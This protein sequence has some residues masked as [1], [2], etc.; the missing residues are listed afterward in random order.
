MDGP[1]WFFI[2]IV[3]GLLVGLVYA[4]TVHEQDP[5]EDTLDGVP[6]YL[7]TVVQNLSLG[8][9]VYTR[10]YVPL[11]PAIQT[12]KALL[13]GLNYTG[14][15]YR[16]YGCINDTKRLKSALEMRGFTV[17]VCTDETI[18]RPTYDIMLQKIKTFVAS[19]RYNDVGFLWYSGHG[20]LKSSRN[21]WVPLDF[22]ARGYIFE[23]TVRNLLKASKTKPKLFVGSDSC[24]SGSFFDLKYDIEP[25][26]SIDALLVKNAFLQKTRELPDRP[27]Q[28]TV[29][30]RLADLEQPI[31]AWPSHIL[32]R[33]NWIP[34]DHIEVFTNLS[35]YGSSTSLRVGRYPTD[36]LDYATQGPIQSLDIPDGLEVTL[37]DAEGHEDILQAGQY[38]SL[39]STPTSLF[40]KSVRTDST[41]GYKN[42]VYDLFD[43]QK[44]TAFEYPIVF[45]SAGRDDQVVYDA[46]IEG[47][48]QGALT[49]A[50]L[51]TIQS[52]V[53]GPLTIGLFQDILRYG[54][55]AYKFPQ[56]PQVSLG[57]PIDPTSRL[58]A[59][60]I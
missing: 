45:V 36:L 23:D 39:S 21:A 41:Q 13:F 11:D 10:H 57:L 26:G 30:E 4:I 42:T 32:D 59:F 58:S 34:T 5:A 12:K 18:E 44:F 1:S 54:L 27:V 33:S 15:P 20:I 28:E 35:L 56:V 29:T 31:E 9:K 24:Y 52:S 8:S 60:G 38:K 43:I 55:N 19:L 16:L 2:L 51:R 17:E 40:V 25:R 3:L 37:Y 46:Y 50:F 14:T 7:Y 22:M 49:W 53:S 47:L 6:K 48:S